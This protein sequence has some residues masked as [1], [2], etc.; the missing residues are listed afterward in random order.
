MI[1]R[2]NSLY[3]ILV[4]I[5]SCYGLLDVSMVTEEVGY[6]FATSGVSRYDD[7]FEVF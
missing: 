1:A 3:I 6:S 2:H 4:H 7:F 5:I